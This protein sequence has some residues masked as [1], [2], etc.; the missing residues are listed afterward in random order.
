MGAQDRATA[1]RFALSLFSLLFC[2]SGLASTVNVM[3]ED[4]PGFAGQPDSAATAAP[5][6]SRSEVFLEQVRTSSRRQAA[7]AAFNLSLIAADREDAGS[8]QR[9]IEEAIQLNPGNANYLRAAAGFAFRGGDYASAEA[10]Q[11][12]VVEKARSRFSGDDPQLAVILDELGIIYIAQNRYTEAGALLEQSLVIR[13]Q[14]LGKMHPSLAKGLNDLAG[15]AMKGGRFDEAEQL[16]KRMLHILETS[17]GTDDPDTAMAIHNLGDFY[18][19][20]KR[21]SEAAVMYRRAVQLWEGAPAK[22]RLEIAAILNEL[23]NFY[24][25]RK[26]LD[27]AK[28]QFEL[29]VTLL[30]GDFGQDH[31][32]V[33]TAIAGLEA[34]KIAGEKRSEVREFSQQMFDELQTLLFGHMQ[35]D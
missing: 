33:K 22:D 13:E 24:R 26:R 19:N 4:A 28:A 16:L 2:G 14:A 6:T 5:A 3:D 35:A 1:P 17:A 21:F 34:L 15:L 27:E 20:Q 29:V 11:L 9:L 30:S 32:Q 23:G 31:P 8:A 10:Y 12:A 18:S 25:S 7:E